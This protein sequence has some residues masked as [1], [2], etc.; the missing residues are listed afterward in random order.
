MWHIKNENIDFQGTRE[1][2]KEQ[3]NIFTVFNE[4]TQEDELADIWDE[5][6]WKIICSDYGIYG[7][8]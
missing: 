2:M 5:R 6:H 4:Q 1:Q 8:D 7:E 3:L